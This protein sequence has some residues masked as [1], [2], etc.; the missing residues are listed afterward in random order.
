MRRAIVH[1]DFRVASQT[2]RHTTYMRT[3]SEVRDGE[4]KYNHTCA[5]SGERGVRHMCRFVGGDV[6]GVYKQ[7]LQKVINAMGFQSI[8]VLS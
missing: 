1:A 6:C 5:S 8:H 3:L 4:P 2:Q 7:L